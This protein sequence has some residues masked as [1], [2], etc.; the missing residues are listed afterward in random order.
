MDK[1]K[2]LLD[3][4]A[5]VRADR[6]L[7]SEALATDRS[8]SPGHADRLYARFQKLTDIIEALAEYEGLLR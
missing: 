4:I 5:Y 2:H 1:S 3:L 8:V 7:V 6:D